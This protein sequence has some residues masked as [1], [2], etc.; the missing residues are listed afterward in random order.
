MEEPWSSNRETFVVRVLYHQNNTWQGEVLWAE[1]N[2]KRHFRSAIELMELMGSAMED[3]GAE[4][5]RRSWDRDREPNTS[6][7][8]AR[9][10]SVRKGPALQETMPPV[11]RRE[12]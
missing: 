6:E 8:N 7:P 10:S 1:Q 2:E 11:R 12:F 5:T 3:K 4:R 9:E